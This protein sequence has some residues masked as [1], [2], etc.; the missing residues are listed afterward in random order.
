MA[1]NPLLDFEFLKD[2][3]LQRNKEVF[4]KLE[5]L[6]FQELPIETIEGRA[7][8]GTTNVDG[9]SAVRRTCSLSLVANE[10]NIHDYYWGLNS[11]FKVYKGYKNTIN[12]EYPDI[13]WFPMGLYLIT[14]FNTSENLNSYTI[15]IQGKDKMALLNGE[16]GGNVTSLTWDFGSIDEIDEK[17]VITN[18]K[19]LIKNIIREAVH[20]FAKE[21]Y[22][23]IIINDL[24]ELAVELLEYRNSF[25]LYM[26]YEVATDTITNFGFSAT[27]SGLLR[28]DNNSPVDFEAEDFVFNPLI[29]LDFDTGVEPT[30]V[31]PQ[32]EKDRLF[33]I[34]KVENGQ[35]VGYRET[36]LVYAGDLIANVG[37]PV[38]SVFDRIITMLGDFEYF[39]NL[40]GQFV[41]QRKKLY[42]NASWNP[43]HLG[44]NA[45]EDYS[46]NAAYSHSFIYSF[47][48]SNLVT[49]FSNSPNY[50]NLKNDYSIW[51][52]KRTATGVELPVHLRCAI[53]IKP[54]NYVTIAGKEYSANEYDWRELIY[55]MAL[56]Y[57]QY[58]HDANTEDAPHKDALVDFTTTLAKNNPQYPEGVT[59][60]EQYYVDMEGFWRQLYDPSYKGSYYAKYLTERDYVKNTYYIME[61]DE[62]WKETA[63]Y[64]ENVGGHYRI[65]PN[66][67]E[68][69][70]NN[71]PDNYVKPRKASEAFDSNQS[72]YEFRQDE[73]DTETHW[74]TL[75]V[76]SPESINFWFDF[77]DGEDSELAKYAVSKVGLRTKALNDSGV[78]A[79]YFREVPTVIFVDSTEDADEVRRLRPGY[80]ILQLKESIKDLFVIS[81]RGKSAKEKLNELLYTH[82]YC[83]ESVNIST[84]PVCYLEPNSRIEIKDKNSGIN[85]IYNI[86]RLSMPL[87]HNGNMTITATRA[88]DR[89]I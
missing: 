34:I 24:D 2:L 30:L 61:K 63:T 7:T 26:R 21:P 81:G 82:S 3:D 68:G 85:G 65:V 69:Q 74:T 73:F 12:S 14:S 50:A 31:Y 40:D 37:E 42:N 75:L 72:Y 19:Y 57:N 67:S 88:V 60:Y 23:N 77:V 89:M 51:G 29:E 44:E 86:S 56:D 22:Y 17:G 66:L 54:E 47:E 4:C 11:K 78:K 16:M 76:N 38:T 32:G 8:N 80:A 20:E 52:T 84:I 33:S 53:D 45:K 64:A 15:N 39:Y 43:I 49:S 70:F 59:G 62:V 28:A 1:K 10:L 6:N 18:K 27:P 48:D 58:M 13:I 35:T 25:P 79:I 87:N 41:F 46:E 5:A 83:V 9:G 71:N 55:Q 36:D